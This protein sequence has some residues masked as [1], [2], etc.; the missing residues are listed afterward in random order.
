VL[1]LLGASVLLLVLGLFGNGWAAATGRVLVGLAVAVT[2]PLI[3]PNWGKTAIIRYGAACLFFLSVFRPG[4]D[5]IALLIMIMSDDFFDDFPPLRRI[6]KE[7][8]QTEVQH[9]SG[10][11]RGA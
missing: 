2:T 3:A 7:K 11:L 5:M 10:V 6:P 9:I 8:Q 1:G 4:L